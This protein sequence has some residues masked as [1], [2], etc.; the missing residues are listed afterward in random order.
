[1]KLRE[2]LSMNELHLIPWLPKNQAYI[3]PSSVKCPVS[4]LA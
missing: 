4:L 2:K 3:R 1:M